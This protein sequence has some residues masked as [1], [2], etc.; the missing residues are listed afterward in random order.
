MHGKVARIHH[1]QTGVFKGLPTP[2]EAARYHSLFIK[3]NALPDCL[4]VTATS[5]DDVIMAIKHKV[6]P[7]ASLQFH[8][9]SILTLHKN[10][11]LKIIT[12]AIAQL[13]EK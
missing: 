8:P 3:P 5:D 6:L 13:I 4:E 2:M 11:G 10:A 1:N 12:N 7:I 9:E